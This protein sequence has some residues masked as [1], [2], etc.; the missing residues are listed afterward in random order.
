MNLLTL[1]TVDDEQHVHS[2]LD[3]I[4][5]W[6]SLG[7]DHVGAAMNG[8]EAIEQISRLKPDIIMTDVR[9]P[10]MNGI[11]LIREVR[12][13]PDYTPAI[14][15]ASGYDE[16]EYAREALRHGVVDY[17]LKPVD[18][19]EL[20]HR[21]R[22]IVRLQP[23]KIVGASARTP[24]SRPELLAAI[25]APPSPSRAD[26]EQV[27]R[28][29]TD[30]LDS[31]PPFAVGLIVP[32]DLTD[33]ED[34]SI[35]SRIVTSLGQTKVRETASWTYQD[36]ATSFGFLVADKALRSSAPHVDLWTRGLHRSLSDHLQSSVY[37]ILGTPVDSVAD[38]AASRASI[39]EQLERN[40]RIVAPGYEVVGA[41]TSPLDVLEFVNADEIIRAV[42]E[43]SI[44]AVDTA[45]YAA[46]ATVS[47]GTVTSNAMRDWVVGLIRSI[48]EILTDLGGDPLEETAAL[49]PLISDIG[50][51]PLKTIAARVTTY[52][53]AAAVGIQALS[54]SAK[55]GR[56]LR[57]RR[58][59]EERFAEEL[60]LAEVAD[61]I[62]VN[63]VYLGQQ[64]K[65]HVGV[66]F[67]EYQRR[68]RINEACRLLRTSN[69]RVADI[70]RAVGYASY[71]YFTEQ[72][73][74]E[75][76]QTPTKYRLKS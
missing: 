16:F 32:M 64:F 25:V 24:A 51:V 59:I 23:T 14:I 40:Y 11:D 75:T 28:A 49:R 2:G 70:A 65:V 5:D 10:V 72:F 53:R 52:L 73:R 43:G 62:G 54:E 15:V 71:D 3:A 12:S 42:E 67:K 41:T 21:L 55:H 58:I 9:M 44:D 61:E 48:N 1:L 47:T 7:V 60:T 66:G 46:L 56:V 22:E 50:L 30:E 8:A 36:K 31:E 35:A 37:L 45:L 26:Y 63:A 4:M 74:R 76:G 18:E 34:E 29:V 17:M 38:L 13:I 39:T 57:L 20:A 33:G 19:D 68:C 6:A 27:V 69:D